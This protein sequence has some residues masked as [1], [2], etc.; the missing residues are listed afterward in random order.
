MKIFLDTAD[1]GEIREVH[2]WGI[3]D[4]VTTNP[5]LIAKQGGDFLETIHSICEL[6]QGPVSAEVIAQDAEGMIREGRLLSRV[7]EHVVVKVPLTPA[8]ISATSVLAG[9][10]I[11]VNVTLCFNV[12]QAIFAAKAGAAYVSPFVGRLDDASEDGMALIEQIVT[13]FDN[14]PDLD[15]EVL[16][17]SIRH[18]RHVADC[19]RVGA[20]VITAPYKVL[21]QAIQHPLTDIGNKKFLADW[22]TVKD[23]DIEAA[24]KRFL[25]RR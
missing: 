15:T 19:A 12:P 13:A 1:L 22:A 24:A 23:N 8:G 11:P 7:H 9:E 17:A 3:L 21:V 16:A 5:S 4:G 25:A 14:Y 6:V 2:A 18:P 20:D 10:G